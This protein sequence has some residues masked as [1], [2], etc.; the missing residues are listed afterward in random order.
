MRTEERIS[1]LETHIDILS[2]R[3]AELERKENKPEIEEDDSVIE[4]YRGDTW[5]YIDC[6]TTDGD[7]ARIEIRHEDGE[8]SSLIS[9]PTEDGGYA[10]YLTENSTIALAKFLSEVVEEATGNW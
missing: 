9:V 7:I 1:L 10:V 3:V 6:N 2:R 4:S 5:S 8:I